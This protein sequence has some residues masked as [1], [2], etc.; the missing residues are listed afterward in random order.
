[1]SI[2]ALS[3]YLFT[4]TLPSGQML[5]HKKLGIHEGESETWQVPV[6]VQTESTMMSK[7]KW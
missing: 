5:Q 4:E 1:M 7:S 2:I 6:R 3:S